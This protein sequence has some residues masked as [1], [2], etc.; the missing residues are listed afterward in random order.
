MKK[1]FSCFLI[2]LTS[3]ISASSQNPLIMDQFTADPSARVFEGKVYLYPSH[4]IPCGKGQGFIGFC[5]ADYHVFSSE[6]LTDWMDHGIIISQNQVPW[7]DST[8]YSLWAP[9]CIYK[10]GKYY[11]YFP[12]RARGRSPFMSQTIGV[13]VSDKP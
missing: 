4:D 1:C 6:N 13:A 10:D 3:F 8:S 11:F 12:A 5:M 7:V 2:T 9:D